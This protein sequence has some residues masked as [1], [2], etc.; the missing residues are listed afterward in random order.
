MDEFKA[1][2]AVTRG[3]QAQTLLDN[4]MLQEAFDTLEKAYIE[5][6]RVSHIDDDKGREKLFIAVNVVGKVKEHLSQIVSN[7]KMAAKQLD[8]LAKEAERKKRF[9]IV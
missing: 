8:D 7:G 2:Q 1:N 5:R 3:A 6:W 4:A 9:G